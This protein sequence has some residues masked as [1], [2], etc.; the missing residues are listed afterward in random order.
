MN[1]A[2]VPL[3]QGDDAVALIRRSVAYMEQ[4]CVLPWAR[5]YFETYTRETSLVIEAIFKRSIPLKG[6]I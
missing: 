5:V 6:E 3:Q 4:Y 2:L 1:H